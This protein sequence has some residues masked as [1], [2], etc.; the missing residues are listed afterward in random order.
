MEKIFLTLVLCTI[1]NLI[2][3]FAFCKKLKKISTHKS[4]PTYL[5]DET[6]Y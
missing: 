1:T 3:Y 4:V 5:N 6:I 2:S